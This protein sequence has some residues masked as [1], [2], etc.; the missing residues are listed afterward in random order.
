MSKIEVNSKNS[1]DKQHRVILQDT[2]HREMPGR[3][4]PAF[5]SGRVRRALGRKTQGEAR[6]RRLFETAKDGILI[7]DAETGIIEDVNPFLSELLGFSHEEIHG[8]ALWELGSLK[9]IVASKDHFLELQQKEY[10]R[11]EDLPLTTRYGKRINV[12]FISNVYQE[13]HRKVI[14]C[15]IRDITEHK[16]A[17]EE[18][19]ESED[20]YRNLTDLLPQVI[21]ETDIHGNLTFVNQIGFEMFNY[22]LQNLSGK[23]NV[24]DMIAPQDRDEAT[25]N[26]VKIW[27]GKLGS[28]KEFMAMRHDGTQF[29]VIIYA[30]SILRKGR[31]VGMR[32]TLI[33]ITERKRM[34]DE[35]LQVHKLESL[36]ILAGGIAHDFNNLMAI[37]QGYI[38]LACIDLPPDH[39]SRQRLLNAM[40]S[41]EQTK[42]LTSRLIT[43]SQGGGPH[44]EI[45]DITETIRNAVHRTV[46]G[47]EVKVTFDF[48]DNLWLADVD[49]L[50]MKQCFSSLIVNA[51]EAMREGGNLTIRA[52]NA[53]IDAEEVSDLRE[54]SYLKIVF[55]D[56]GSGIP[57]E[58]LLKIFDPYFTTKEMG[59]QKGMGLGLAVCYSVLKKHSGHIMVKS[60]TGKGSSFILHLPARARQ[61]EEMEIKKKVSTDKNRVLIMDDEIKMVRPETK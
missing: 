7:L 31:V 3:G 32:G 29:P 48:M 39:V 59:S 11:F 57:E 34:E 41:V 8:K 22:P 24:L 61:S 58:N 19:K 15:N 13:N 36:G 28:A 16:K 2:A 53:L 23:V 5:K 26:A 46:K 43:F 10:I 35:L 20:K 47:T 9:D 30:N 12:E 38:D 33:D 49:E 51:A 54:G 17:S 50:Q 27:G 14:Q 55:T 40:G 1:K 4:L 37:V 21:F 25:K 52:E 45:V 60:Q 42:D 56:E 44:R 6:Y 18:L